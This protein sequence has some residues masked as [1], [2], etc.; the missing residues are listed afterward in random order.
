MIRRFAL[1]IL[2]TV[3][4]WSSPGTRDWVAAMSREMDF[5]ENDWAALWWALGS[6]ADSFQ[7]SVCSARRLVGRPAGRALPRENGSPADDQRIGHHVN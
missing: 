2:N 6:Y 4:R 3:A 1:K 5:I 7:A